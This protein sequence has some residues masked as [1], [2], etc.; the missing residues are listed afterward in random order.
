MG[1]GGVQRIIKLIKYLPVDWEVTVL[2][3]DEYGYTKDYSLL[4]D[5]PPHVAV[6]RIGNIT[7]MSIIASVYGFIL[8]GQSKRESDVGKVK[9]NKK[10]IYFSRL[11][12]M[13]L[14]LYGLL[15]WPDDKIIWGW[16]VYSR[17][18]RLHKKHHYDLVISS[19]PP[20]S[21]HWA[22][23][24]LKIKYGITWVADFRD[25]WTNNPGYISSSYRNNMDIK[26]ENKIIDRAN[27]ILTVTPGFA[28]YFKNTANKEKLIYYLPNGY[29]ESDFDGSLKISAG[30]GRVEV[31]HTGSLYGHQSPIPLLEGL[32]KAISKYPD[33]ASNVSFR[34]IGSVGEYYKIKLNT[35]ANNYPGLVYVHEYMPHKE[36]V[37]Y[38]LSSDV[39]L[40]IVGG[41]EKANNVLPGKIFEY[42][43]AN[44]PI[45]F[46]GPLG[47][48]AAVLLHE[49]G[50]K[51]KV[52]EQNTDQ[53][54]EFILNLEHIAND[55][56][57]VAASKIQQY[58]RKN[59]AERFVKI[60]NG[61]I[62]ARN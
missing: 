16:R 56:L 35:W 33:I 1:G 10:N 11:K 4:E 26:L 32:E 40:L 47:G 57:T 39:L 19:S 15:I 60:I 21:A 34:F 61:L 12:L 24:Q 29:D 49:Y 3:A 43:R 44:K 14:N 7:P 18:S 54:A 37:S 6:H 9:P 2:S 41:G 20:I 59:L 28:S 51:W 5:L 23:L 31:L 55:D 58:S 22:A 27:A 42:L 36:L 13:V 17:A 52:D 53:L 45:L 38:L 50:Y 48:D 46:I 25:L 62:N 8:A 30:R